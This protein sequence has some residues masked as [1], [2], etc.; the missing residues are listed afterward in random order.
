MRSPTYL[1]LIVPLIL[2]TSCNRG[3][4]AGSVATQTKSLNDSAPHEGQKSVATEADRTFTNQ[5]S[6]KQVDNSQSM[7]QAMERKIIRNGE[8]IL[9]VNAPQDVQ[10]KIASIA[11][12]LGGFVVTS[13]SKQR[14]SS[15]GGEP[16]IEVSLVI[17][18]PATQFGAALDQVRTAGSRV[19][20]E[21]ITGEDVTEE[22][23][24]LEARIKTQK[25]LEDQFLEIMKRANKVE[26]ALEV[27]RQIADVRT[28][29]EKLEGRKRFL[30]NRAS[31]S[32]I[33]VNLQTPSAV[34]VNTTGFGRDIREAFADSVEVARAIVLFLIRFV[35]IMIPIFILLILPLG[36]L[37]RYFL[38]RAKRSLRSPAPAPDL[39][40]PVSSD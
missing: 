5:V 31:L 39:P 7:A 28:E 8:L 38:R 40:P 33:T 19:I 22:F 37:A 34:V 11:E 4:S 2:F 26:D 30:E 1:L 21:K 24:D 20:A 9:E 35:I 17:R 10:R 23:I 3:S 6:L 13:E 14:Q 27:Q 15:N 32:T 29:I 25:A 16:S 12:S 18:V 36:L